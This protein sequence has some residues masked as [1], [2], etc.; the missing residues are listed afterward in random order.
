MR[1]ATS[2]HDPESVESTGVGAED[3]VSLAD[4]FVPNAIAD[5]VSALIAVSIENHKDF[6]F[7]QFSFLAMGE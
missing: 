2:S 1:I 7:T 6:V 5:N 4:A 3:T